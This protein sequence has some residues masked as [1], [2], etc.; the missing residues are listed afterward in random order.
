VTIDRR[1]L[2]GE[3]RG[4][5]LDAIADLPAA[6]DATLQATVGVGEYV[7]FTGR[8]LRHEKFFPAW[9]LPEDDW[10]VQQ[11]GRGLAE[12][13]LRPT[14]GAYRF[15][16]N[17]AHSAGVAGIPTVGF[18]PGTEADAHVVDERLRIEDLAAAAA[19]YRGIIQSVLE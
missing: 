16:T 3:T 2:P 11:A 12:V 18:G 1:T 8:K 10:L 17:A 5:V 9:V 13:G 4:D 7:T 14:I 19:G 15:C 6:R